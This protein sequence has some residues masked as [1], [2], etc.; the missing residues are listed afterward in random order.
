MVFGNAEF[1]SM[2]NTEMSIAYTSLQREKIG[3]VD[4]EIPSNSFTKQTFTP[5]D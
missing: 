5:L 1:I 4:E 2:L 3:V